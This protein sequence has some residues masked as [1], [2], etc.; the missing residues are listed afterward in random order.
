MTKKE[1]IETIKAHLQNV[2][3]DR[4]KGIV[5][6]GSEARGDNNIDSDIDILVLLEGPIEY[7]KD[8]ERNIN[9]LYPLSLE[10]DRRISAKPVDAEE[11]NKIRCPLYNNAHKEGVLV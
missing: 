6:Y 4:L 1:I 9:S 11:Y 7:G 10:L 3:H 5:L 2:Y 8:L